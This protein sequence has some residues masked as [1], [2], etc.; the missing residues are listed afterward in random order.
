VPGLQRHH[1]LPRQLLSQRCFAALFNDIGPA[2]V[3]YDDFLANGVLLPSSDPAALRI[4]LPLHRGPHRA[5][6][7]MVIERIGQIENSWARGRAREPVAARIDA[8]MRI[9]LVQRALRRRLLDPRGGRALTL[10]RRQLHESIACFAELDAM[11]DSLWGEL[12]A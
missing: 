1:L 8:A 10:N 3:G 11:A 7:A 6:N 4:G 9:E 2:R 5:Y 12:E